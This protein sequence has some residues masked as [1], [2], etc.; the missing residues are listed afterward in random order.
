MPIGAVDNRYSACRL[1]MRALQWA[2]ETALRTLVMKEPYLL[3]P[4]GRNNIRLCWRCNVKMCLVGCCCWN[5]WWDRKWSDEGCLDSVLHAAFTTLQAAGTDVWGTCLQSL[6]LL[7]GVFLI[8]DSLYLLAES[9]RNAYMLEVAK[10]DLFDL[11][12]IL[13]Y[14]YKQCALYE[15]SVKYVQSLYWSDMNVVQKIKAGLL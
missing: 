4:V 3:L 8:S 9:V 1:Y 5:I 6:F 14:I 7:F 2:V 11:C 12:L 13:H 15:L 10:T